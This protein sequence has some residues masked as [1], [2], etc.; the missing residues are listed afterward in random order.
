MKLPTSVSKVDSSQPLNALLVMAKHPTPGQS[1]TRLCPPLSPEQ[2]AALY[3][4]LLRDTLHLMRQVPETQPVIAYFPRS[5]RDYFARLAPDFELWPQ[6]GENLGARLDYVLTHYLD[7]GYRRVVAMNSDGPTLPAAHLVTAFEALDE[8]KTDVVLG[9][10]EDG[11]YYLIGMKQPA[12]RLLREVEMSTPHVA[13]DTLILARAEGLDV[14]ILPGWYDVDD[15]GSLSRLAEELAYAPA[16]I[17]PHTREFLA[18]VRL[19]DK[20]ARNS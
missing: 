9:P 5:A 20:I 1:K 16:E 15:G 6:A 3:E 11:G 17:A 8:D 18:G 7:R 19:A 13:A 10:S 4:C 12:P 2:A 14:K